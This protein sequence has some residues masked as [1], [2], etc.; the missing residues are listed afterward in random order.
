M[1]GKGPV[2]VTGD[3]DLGLVGITGDLGLGG[4]GNVVLARASPMLPAQEWEIC[5]CGADG[6]VPPLDG[7]TCGPRCENALILTHV[8]TQSDRNSVCA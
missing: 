3:G 4:P 7:F 2:R 5:L 8:C 6:C 1:D